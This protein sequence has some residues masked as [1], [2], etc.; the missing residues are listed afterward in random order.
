[1]FVFHPGVIFSLIISE[2]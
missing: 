1:M 2:R